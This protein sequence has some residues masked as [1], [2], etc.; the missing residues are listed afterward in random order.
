MRPSAHMAF[1]PMDV[2][3]NRHRRQSPQ[4]PVKATPEELHELRSI[5]EEWL[6]RAR[7]AVWTFKKTNGAFYRDSKTLDRSSLTTTARCYMALASVE[8]QLATTHQEDQEQWPERFSKYI[9]SLEMT[10]DDSKFKIPEPSASRKEIECDSLNNFEIA[11]LADLEFARKFCTRFHTEVSETHLERPIIPKEKDTDY[12]NT[13]RFLTNK[14]ERD[15]DSVE[16]PFDDSSDSSDSSRHYFVTLH[17]LRAIKIFSIDDTGPIRDIGNDIAEKARLFCIEQCFYFQREI[18]HKQDPARLV[19]ASSLYC[20]YAHAVDRELMVAIVEAILGMQEPSGKWPASHPVVMGD[21]KGLWYI[22]SAELALC[23]TWLYFQPKLPD[24]ARQLISIMLESHFRNWI[25]P[26]YTQIRKK[27]EGQTKQQ[28]FRGWF[29]DSAIGQQ[30]V[31][32]WATAIVCNF[33]ANYHMVLNDHINRTVIASLELTE[34]AERYI[35]DAAAPNRNTRWSTDAATDNEIICWPDLPPIAWSKLTDTTII[36]QRLQESWS[37]PEVDAALSGR[38]AFHVLLPIFSGPTFFPDPEMVAGILDGPPGTRKTSLVREISR[39]LQWPYIPVPALAIFEHGFDN[40]EARA[41]TV[42]RRLNYLTQCVVFFDEFEEFFRDRKE[43]NNG[44]KEPSY[45]EKN[46]ISP[47][48]RTIAA[49]T[50]SAMLPRLQALHDSGQSLIFLATNHF[51]RID[52]A[53]VRSGRFDF[54]ETVDHPKLDRFDGSERSYFRAP[55]RHT[56]RILK[57]E[58]NGELRLLASVIKEA[59]EAKSLKCLL[60]NLTENADVIPNDN[61]TLRIPFSIVD[62][63]AKKVAAAIRKQRNDRT[64]PCDAIPAESPLV[65]LAVEVLEEQIE[66]IAGHRKGPGPLP[67]PE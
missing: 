47:H 34:V 61:S 25:I 50:T 46:G 52:D 31:V 43:A 29:D 33:L 59:L 45:A 18:K 32:G 27:S 9:E 17:I 40:M 55:T 6:K 5:V 20:M 11:H 66:K 44:G 39:I 26:T 15:T 23:L 22:A 49:F 51:K 56:R 30:K 65:K 36:A 1:P 12:Q 28:V 42:F 37:D 53:I 67:I 57:L 24:A 19:F 8:R 2:H 13:L 41:S 4:E 63:V 35:V 62:E 10:V 3:L 16:V 58:S 14:L 60:R 54:R 21:K 64:T 7:K 38:M 48:N